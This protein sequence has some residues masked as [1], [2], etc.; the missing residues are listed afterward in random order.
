[1]R[2]WRKNILS[3]YAL[4]V[5]SQDLCFLRRLAGSDFQRFR[6]PLSEQL[7]RGVHGAEVEALG[8][9]SCHARGLQSLVHAIHAIIALLSLSSLGIPLGDPPRAG[10]YAALAPYAQG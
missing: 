1:M 2:Q 10:G 8:E 9:A 5:H 3:L 7:G 4:S 6:V